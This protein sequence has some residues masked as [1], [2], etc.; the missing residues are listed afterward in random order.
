MQRCQIAARAGWREEVRKY[1]PTEALWAEGSYYRFTERQIE[2]LETATAELRRLML[3]AVEKAVSDPAV[4][5]RFHVPAGFETM[6]R[7]S[8]RSN[9]PFVY[10]RLDLVYDGKNPPRL[11]EYN[12]DT[13][14]LLS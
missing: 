9:D 2:Q 11:M 3:A 1:L 13:P 12:G 4:F 8:W 6:V 10:E 5:T 7:E 14:A